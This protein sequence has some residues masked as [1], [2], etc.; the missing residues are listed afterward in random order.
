M[1][2]LD[3]LRQ[4]MDSTATRVLLTIV[5]LAFVGS[6]GGGGGSGRTELYVVVDGQAITRSEFDARMRN[7]A[8]SAA[9]R[10]KRAL[11]DEERN[12]LAADVL[13]DMIVEEV[14]LQQATELRIAVS[15][16]EIAR[17]L[18]GIEAFQKDGKFD[19]YTYESALRENGQTAE[20]FEQSVKRQLLV[21]KVGE[22]AQ[23]GIAI[24]QAEVR[25][26][27]ESN[28]TEL[29]LE[30]VRLPQLAFYDQVVM[31]E[32]EV[33][34]YVAANKEKIK[35]QYDESFERSYNLPKRYTLAEIVLR[36]DMPGADKAATKAKADEVAKLAASGADFAELARTWS[37]D[38]TASSGG[39]LGQRI[40]SQLDPVLITA[41]EA[42]GPGKVSPAVETGRGYEIVKVEAIEDARIIPLEEAEPTIAE[43]MIRA[44]RVVEVQR[45]Y[46]AKIT[47]A[48]TAT[49][50]V[51][52][53][54]T[55]PKMLAVDT[56]GPFSLDAQEIP[57]LGAQPAIRELLKSAA[58]GD[59][60]PLPLEN[61]GTLYVAA[62]KARTEPTEEDFDAQ[63]AGIRAG[64]LAA[65]Q[66]SFFDQWK[67]AL[68]AGATIERNV[69]FKKGAE[70]EATETT[71]GG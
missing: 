70:G 49:K 13:E 51:P 19:Q 36:T 15:E 25:A 59:V 65:K 4:G 3:T 71:E 37:E 10:A 33:A 39:N 63:K 42:A 41:A 50:A 31:A 9:A 11:S 7:A 62:L 27:W 23:A 8:R 52:L 26:A 24:T 53:D 22:L 40:P 2:V 20:R 30:Y 28:A 14:L 12:G 45:A 61:R 18:K 17:V 16:E 64:L 6:M 21:E 43:A 54:L 57:T 32:G 5:A 38:L 67:A 46:A 58:V 48:W 68:V 69:N 34:T 35:K 44:E 66:Q 1:S 60:L 55:E 47:E 29:D 56:T